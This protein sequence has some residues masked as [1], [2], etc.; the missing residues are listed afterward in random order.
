MR[1]LTS[2][3]GVCCILALAFVSGAVS[4]CSHQPKYVIEGK[5]P[6]NEFDGELM[7]LV[8]MKG[9]HPRKV[10]SVRI[11]DGAFRFEGDSFV[12]KVLRSPI[13]LRMRLQEL[14]VV[15]EPGIIRVNIDTVSSGGGTPQNDALQ[16]W[17]EHLSAYN[18]AIVPLWHALRTD[19][20]ADTVSLKATVDSLR[21]ANSQWTYEFLKQWQGTVLGDFVGET[22]KYTL[23]DAQRQELYGEG[24]EMS[25]QTTAP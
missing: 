10:D 17:K 4:S 3:W 20:T 24:D 1:N 16:T 2:K 6:S 12:V 15:T 18:N 11:Q 13:R 9:K 5:L 21:N 25:V 22:V 19:A 14:L 7:Y 23:S 8:P